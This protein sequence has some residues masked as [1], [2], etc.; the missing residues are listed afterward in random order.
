MNKI[1]KAVPPL[2]INAEYP[3]HFLI[4]AKRGCALNS[5]RSLFR[6]IFYKY[7]PIL[8]SLFSKIIYFCK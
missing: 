2:F 4:S 6:N 1:S 8:L 7:L 3:I 5:V